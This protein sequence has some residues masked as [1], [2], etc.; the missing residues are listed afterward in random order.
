MACNYSSKFL[1]LIEYNKR[2]LLPH[3]PEGF[4]AFIVNSFNDDPNVIYKAMNMPPYVKEIKKTK[5]V[6]KVN[7][8]Q[9][10]IVAEES[11]VNSAYLGRSDAYTSMVNQF[12]KR[13]LE[14]ARVQVDFNTGEV[15]SF[16]SNALLPNGLTVLNNN[17]LKY[18]LQLIENI[19]SKT[20]DVNKNLFNDIKSKIEQELRNEKPGYFSNIEDNL[21]LLTSTVKCLS[22]LDEST[23][24]DFIQL[25]NFD[26][27][28]TQ[29]CPYIEID[30]RYEEDGIDKYKYVGS[31][32]IHFSG[33]TANEFADSMDQASMLVKAVLDYIPEIDS[34]GKPIPNSSIGLTGFYS[35]MTALRNTVLYHPDDNL[36]EL[37]KS[38]RDGT[39]CDLGKIIDV[40]IKYLQSPRQL[41]GNVSGYYESHRTYLIGKL[42]GIKRCIFNSNLDGEL[43]DIFNNMFFK[44]VQMNYVAYAF[45]EESNDFAGKDLKNSMI[46]TQLYTL[47]GAMSSSIYNLKRTSGLYDSMINDRDYNNKPVKY[48]VVDVN[49]PNIY[50]INYN[51]KYFRLN[52]NNKTTD[53][54]FGLQEFKDIFYDVFQYIIPEDYETVGKQINGNNWKIENDLKDILA[55]GIKCIHGWGGGFTYQNGF[56]TNLTDNYKEFAKVAKVVSTIY[57]SD[58]VNVVKNVNK[59][60]NLPLYGLTSLAHNFHF[61]MWD[62]MDA[63]PEKDIYADS[64]FFDQYDN[65]G[66][67]IKESLIREPKVRSEVYYNGELKPSTKLTVPEVFKLSFLQDYYQNFLKG[68]HI[69]LQNATFADKGTHFLVNYDLNT[70]VYGDKTLKELIE[71]HMESDPNSSGLFN[72]MLDTRRKRITKLVNNIINDY[73]TAFKDENKNFKSLEAIQNF[74]TEK[75]YN[76]EKVRAK[77]RSKGINF[78]EEIHL[79][80]NKINETILEYSKAFTNEESLKN[81]LNAARKAFV[82]DLKTNRVFINTALNGATKSLGENYKG[83]VED[84]GEIKLFKENGDKVTLHPVLEGYFMANDLL[85]NE[86][87]EIM[88]GG[89]YAHSKD[90]E[91]GRLIAQI[92]RSVIY[93]A[94]MHSFAQGIKNGVAE[95]VKI[96]C[97]PDIKAIVTNILGTTKDD[98]DSM[99]GA[100]LSTPLQARL[101]S[102]SLLDARVG[103]DKKSIGHDIDSEYGRPS[104][105][106]WAVYALTN[107]R[108]RI[109]FRSTVSQETLL[110]K[111]Y[112]AETIGLT[113][114]DVNKLLKQLGDVYYKDTDNTGKYYK[115]TSFD[116]QNGEWIRSKQEVDIHGNVIGEVSYDYI[117]N[118]DTLWDIDQLF[119]GAWSMSMT[120]GSLD[121]AEANVDALEAYVTEY[122]KAKTAQI[123]YLV[124][125]SAMKVGVGNLNTDASWTDNSNLDYITMSTRYLGVQMDA[126]HELEDSDVTEMTQMI[127]AISS[128]GYTSDI[129]NRVYKDIGNVIL[130]ALADYD[131]A[132]KN[133]DPKEIYKLLGE[134]F[135]KS[136]ENNDRDTLGLA[137]AFVLKASKALKE[138]NYEFRLPFSAETVNGIFIS[139]VS[140]LLTKKGI[141][142]K[143]E[144]FAGVLTP[145]HDMIQ[146]Y[147]I[148]GTNMMYEQFADKVREMGIQSLYDESGRIIKTAI[149]RA[150]EDLIIDGRRNPFLIPI[151]PS[152]VDFEDTVVVFETDD[153]GKILHIEPKIY[154]IKDFGQY[155]AFKSLD[156]K[157]KKVYNFT[158]RPKNLKGTNT[159]FK[160]N[161]LQKTIY[162]LDSVRAAYYYEQGTNPEFVTAVLNLYGYTDVSKL[163][164]SK[165]FQKIIQSNLRSLKK[166]LPIRTIQLIDGVYVPSEF[167]ATDVYVAPAQIV[168]GRFHAKEFM[169]EPTDKFSDIK[170]QESEFFYRKLINKYGF[171]STEPDWTKR[172]L[173]ATN[174]EKYLVTTDDKTK[175]ELDGYVKDNSIQKFGNTFYYG[176]VKIG[177]FENVEFYTYNDNG[178][179]RKVIVTSPESKEELNKSAF[180]EMWRDNYTDDRMH[181]ENSP[182]HE[183][184]RIR[185]QRM[186]QSFELQCKMLG[187]RIPTQDM[188]S[189]MPEEII[190]WTDSTVNDLYVPV[191]MFVI[192][193]NDLKSI[194][195]S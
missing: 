92:K 141:R 83:W 125:K 50:E 89:V 1:P 165:V 195:R 44:N 3:D 100:G 166:G 182:F 87:N 59:K 95:E 61:V 20:S 107:A 191:Q 155:D 40:Y 29:Q 102:N 15:K 164:V 60:K 4:H 106:K 109:A 112:S 174:G 75:K 114:S 147:N 69:Y 39:K 78:Y 6:V 193:G 142:R 146:Y 81:R 181:R 170:E 162:D 55:I 82:Q 8:K 33:W 24:D 51:G 19:L 65:D 96:A 122:Q 67:L 130:E 85:S 156:F 137:Q 32:V 97:M 18:K 62:H 53:T 160:V 34:T 93:G 5:E 171:D 58:I 77:F 14:F 30:T 153:T 103:Y 133:D 136:F 113:L 12:R 175:L 187:T 168:T 108:R 49:N 45:D 7:T 73:N 43:K 72:L 129:A 150:V 178:K 41:R 118:T 71:E 79:S 124:N 148:G 145:S 68:D 139:T 152:E 132:I 46:N 9:A 127:S 179:V 135:V 110:R 54:N 36:R 131:A 177:T 26:K 74:L 169:L 192:K 37:R 121:Y 163:N 21:N 117:A 140:S 144:G 88:I 189:F 180:F 176:D 151:D 157:N 17:I 57:G 186:W 184:M 149:Q 154:Y 126:E 91:S 188:Q 185:A 98:Q 25:T 116:E 27:L 64:F 22:T 172:V 159:K 105:L 190:G 35:V 38:L 84:G 194:L 23:Y 10:F 76:Q 52:K 11:N 120:D 158:S 2:M 86:Y 123:G 111:M 48:K 47:T 13:M 99:D 70:K 80:K 31:K 101:E 161:G 56:P 104:L 115:I 134:A 183:R 94:T 42:E 16:D 128:H 28:L 143:Y 138:G 66:K 119:G 173:F 63:N 167:T 90:T